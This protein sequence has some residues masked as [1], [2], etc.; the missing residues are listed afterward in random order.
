MFKTITYKE[1]DVVYEIFTD[2]SWN[3]D[4]D[5]Y[6]WETVNEIEYNNFNGTKRRILVLELFSKHS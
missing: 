1:Q 5:H 3:E 4:G 2:T 6:D